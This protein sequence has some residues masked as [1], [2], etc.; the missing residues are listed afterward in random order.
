[1]RLSFMLLAAVS[2]I[3]FAACGPGHPGI[4]SPSSGSGIG[5]PTGW[6]GGVIKPPPPKPEFVLTDTGGHQFD[7][8]R[9]TQGKITLLYFGYTHCPDACPADMATLTGALRQLPA[10]LRAQVAVVFVTTDPARD[11]GPELRKWLDNFDKTYIGLTGTVA[12]VTAAQHATPGIILA[13]P[14]TP[15]ASGRYTVDHSAFVIAFTPD[16]KMRLIYPDGVTAN[17]EAQ[18]LRRLA[19]GEVPSAA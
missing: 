13:A 16:N 2:S 12:E 9:D 3:A 7:F 14:E 18:D 15:D 10:D 4:A 6:A 11:T 17:G 5:T 19:S 1:M 8:R